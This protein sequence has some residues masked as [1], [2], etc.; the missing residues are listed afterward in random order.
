MT[1]KTTPLL[2]FY[3]L[4][5]NLAI[6]FI[7]LQLGAINVL[8]ENQVFWS[9]SCV[10]CILEREIGMKLKNPRECISETLTSSQIHIQKL[11]PGSR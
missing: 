7:N 1:K 8:A 4:R 6:F 9:R 3:H 10:Y 2:L 5:E 11:V